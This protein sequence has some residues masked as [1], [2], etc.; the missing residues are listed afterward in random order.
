MKII[1]TGGAGFIGSHLCERL[2]SAGHQVAIIDE[3]NDYYAPQ[4]K[5]RNLEQVR[6]AGEVRFLQSD[7]CDQ[8]AVSA[9]FQDFAPECVV[10]L[11][12]RAGVR[13]SL[14]SPLL[15]QHANVEGTTLL[16]EEARKQGVGRFVFA[17]SSSVYGAASRVP[18]SEDDAVRWPISPYAAT[19]IAGEALCHTYSHLYGMQIACLRFFTVFGPRQRPDLAIRKFAHNIAAGRPIQ[20]FGDGSTGRDYTFV[21]DTVGGIVAAIDA[22]V[23][24]DVFNLGNSHP[25]L[26]RDMI[27]TIEKVV[28]RQAIVERRPEQPG[29]V[30]I[31]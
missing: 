31:T 13:P 7:I 21:S 4:L 22:N 20:V 12:A 26:L 19:K 30:P 2:L 8:P 29:D 18:F 15:Y 6:Q 27:A 24:F 16:L 23:R 1:V 9:L 25:I 11:A 10:H 17:S 3:L 14:D 28:G 5:L